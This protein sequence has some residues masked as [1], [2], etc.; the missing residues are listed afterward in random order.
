M[1]VVMKRIK[2]LL[3]GL[4]AALCLTSCK[5]DEDFFIRSWLYEET[6]SGVFYGVYLSIRDN[7][8][9]DLKEVT[10]DRYGKDEVYY[11]GSWSLINDEEIRCYM[12]DDAESYSWTFRKKDNNTLYWV[13]EDIDLH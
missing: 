11:Y 12:K 9:C 8:Q 10:E 2:I 5:K 13:G 7:A 4:F 1:L 3:F 6:D